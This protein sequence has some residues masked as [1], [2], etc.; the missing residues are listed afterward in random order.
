M[1]AKTFKITMD[2]DSLAY[3][4]RLLGLNLEQM[5]T[6]ELEEI[7]AKKDDYQG[8]VY[9]ELIDDYV[10]TID[11]ASGTSNYFD[12][13]VLWRDVDGELIEEQMFDCLFALGIDFDIIVNNTICKIQW[14]II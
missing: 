7:G 6:L 9:L 14:V 13:V 1:R 5:D 4:N 3:Y 8:V 11:V 10:L 2:R 12:N